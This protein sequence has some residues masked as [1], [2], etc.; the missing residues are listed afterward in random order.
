MA[1]IFCS[2]IDGDAESSPVIETARVKAFMDIGP[3]N[4]GHVLVVPK[5][6][7]G[8]IVDLDPDDGADMFRVSQVITSALYRS[9]IP[10]DGVNVML[11][12]G[13]A[14]GQEVLHVHL[15]VVPRFWNDGFI[16]RND[17]R[18]AHR[19]SLEETAAIIRDAL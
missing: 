18:R 12:D 13:E 10:S 7:A 6:H 11:S 17:F 9:S 5:V 15:H 4:P 19:A 8:S 1:C 2:I 16:I 14:A 3:I